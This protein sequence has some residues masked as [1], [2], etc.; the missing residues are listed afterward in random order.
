MVDKAYEFKRMLAWRI[1]SDLLDPPLPTIS[2]LKLIPN[3][4]GW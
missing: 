4:T 3:E 1:C 2:S